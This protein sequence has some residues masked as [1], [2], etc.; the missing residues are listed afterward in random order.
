MGRTGG[1]NSERFPGGK[2]EQ[3]RWICRVCKKPLTG[4]R[5]SFCG[6]RC[7]RDFF[8][9]TD[10]PRVR[11]V[12]YARDG[13]VC[14]KCGK[15]VRENDYHVDHIVPLAAGGDEWDLNNLE[16]SCPKCNLQKGAKVE[17]EAC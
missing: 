11:R 12:I 4:R 8:M 1:T 17:T 13:G 7:L 3:G 9:Q 10:W 16:L 2:D 14:M 15:R 5:S 6:P